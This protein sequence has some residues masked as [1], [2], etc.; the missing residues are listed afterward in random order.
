MLFFVYKKVGIEVLPE[1]IYLPI[2]QEL[3]ATKAPDIL[4]QF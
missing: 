1:V 3:I 2:I 4:R